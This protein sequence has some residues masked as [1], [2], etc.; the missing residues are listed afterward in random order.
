[1]LSA[2]C[3]PEAEPISS[4]YLKIRFS[5]SDAV[6]PVSSMLLGSAG[7]KLSSERIEASKLP[8]GDDWVST[9]DMWDNS[10]Q[11]LQVTPPAPPRLARSLGWQIAPATLGHGNA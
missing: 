5:I 2:I 7:R 4:T 1:M 3:R 11:A 6:S 8:V 9:A 10:A